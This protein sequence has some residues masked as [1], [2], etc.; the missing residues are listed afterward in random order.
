MREVVSYIGS[1]PELVVAVGEVA[2]LAELAI[3]SL[4]KMPAL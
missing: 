4:L 2:S 3:S 1:G